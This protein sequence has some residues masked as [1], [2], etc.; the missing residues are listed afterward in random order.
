MKILH[1]AETVRGGIAS[2]I[3]LQL[4]SQVEEF[5]GDSVI[6][7]A[8][9]DQIDCIYFP[10]DFVRATFNRTGRNVFS[11]ARLAWKLFGL[12]VCE[13]PEIVHLHST[14]AG[15]VGRMLRPFLWVMG[16]KPRIIYCPHAWSFLM[17]G[18]K[19][20]ASLFARIEKTLIPLTDRVICVS[21]FEI[22]Q[23]ARYGICGKKID[24]IYNGVP[25]PIVS[26]EK[27]IAPIV[28]VLFVGRFDYQKGYD[29]LL[30]VAGALDQHKFDI[31][32]VGDAV[33][34]K[35]ERLIAPNVTYTGWV[36]SGSMASYYQNAD[37]VVMPSRWEGFSMTLLEAMSHATPVLASCVASFPEVIHDGETGMLARPEDPDDFLRILNETTVVQWHT[38]GVSARKQI[39]SQFSANEMQTRTISLYRDLSQREMGVVK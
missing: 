36:E 11:M 22:E 9:E 1:V 20:R 13:S 25:L 26:S 18:S 14:F 21:R 6:V 16:R 7:L 19:K 28:R 4:Q 35:V 24:L 8:P 3:Q 30:R 12:V 10:R 32:V 37:V 15:A 34:D 23:A 31:T 27:S 2:V 17:H 33:H 39:E 38:M 5:S 29:I